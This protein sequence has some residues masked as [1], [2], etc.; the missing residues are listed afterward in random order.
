MIRINPLLRRIDVQTTAFFFGLYT[1]LFGLW[2]LNP[3]AHSFPPGSLVFYRLSLIAREEYWGFLAILIGSGCLLSL[4]T[5]C[6]GLKQSLNL[7]GLAFWLFILITWVQSNP[8]SPAMVT[9]FVAALSYGLAFLRLGL[10][11]GR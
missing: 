5:T 8:E 7:A 6:I 4:Y 11:D 10:V 3:Y 2:L 9:A 1:L